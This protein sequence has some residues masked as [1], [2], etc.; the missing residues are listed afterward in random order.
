MQLYGILSFYLFTYVR[1]VALAYFIGIFG[2]SLDETL[3]HD[4][5]LG[6]SVSIVSEM[7]ASPSEL[8]FRQVPIIVENCVEFM[9]SNDR[10]AEEGLFRLPGLTNE[11]KDLQDAY[12]MGERPVF[13]Q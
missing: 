3:R 7:T 11:V 8:T 6:S 5:R 4:R 1:Y 10:L 2:Q 13:P 9:R 12:D